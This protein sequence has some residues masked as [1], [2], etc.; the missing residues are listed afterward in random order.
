MIVVRRYVVPETDPVMHSSQSL[1]LAM[2]LI[3]VDEILEALPRKWCL[4]KTGSPENNGRRSRGSNEAVPPEGV[5]I[6][7]VSR[8]LLNPDV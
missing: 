7:S 3:C 1:S 6:P 8:S 2:Q 5:R 4:K